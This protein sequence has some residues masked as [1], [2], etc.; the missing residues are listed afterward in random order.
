[1]VFFFNNRKTKCHLF[2]LLPKMWAIDSAFLVDWIKGEYPAT[3]KRVRYTELLIKDLMLFLVHLPHSGLQGHWALIVAQSKIQEILAFYPLHL[4]CHVE[5][6][7]ILKFLK[8]YSKDLGQL[9]ASE[10]C[11]LKET[12]TSC[13]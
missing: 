2:G 3:R 8:C 13:P 5:M 11:L 7:H 12:A 9:L 10:K 1:M 4:S 6:E